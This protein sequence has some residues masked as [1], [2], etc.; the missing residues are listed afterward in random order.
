MPGRAEPEP[1]GARV[2]HRQAESDEPLVD[3][4]LAQRVVQHASRL[5]REPSVRRWSRVSPENFA[6]TNAAATPLPETSPSA[7]PR[8]FS[9]NGTKS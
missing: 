1:S 2:E 4:G 9:G 3:P 5:P 7:M 8:R 6:I